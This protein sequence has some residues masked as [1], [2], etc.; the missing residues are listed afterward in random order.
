MAA[1][2]CAP[3]LWAT[4]VS[5]AITSSTKQSTSPAVIE[6]TVTEFIKGELGRLQGK[7]AAAQKTAKDSLIAESTGRGDVTATPEYQQTYARVLGQQLQ[8]LVKSPVLRTRLSAAII[9]TQVAEQTLKS[10]GPTEFEPL[11]TALIND[12]EDAVLLYGVKLA[13]YVI[14]DLAVQGKNP[15]TLDKAVIAVVKNHPNTGYLAEE[16]YSALTLEPYENVDGFGK[17]APAVLPDLLALMN[18][19]TT[20]YATAPPASP[21]A[22]EKATVFLAVR[23]YSAASA[24]A[25]RNLVLKAL[26]EA[27]CAVLNQLAQ[28]N[29]S[30]D[31]VSAARAEGGA[32]LVFGNNFSSQPLSSAGQA[33]ATVSANTPTNTVTAACTNLANA[34]KTMGVTITVPGGGASGADQSAGA[35]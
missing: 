18:E 35:K 31:L 9:A 12:K 29:N 30:Q 20:Q 32:L 15:G 22:E 28:G 13:K 34:L 19:R 5:G 2:L 11:A 17:A 14:G 25:T 4:H 10:N 33:I 21:Q 6:P 8:G 7:S 26:G 16:A 1:L 23:A 3:A 24:P 27:V